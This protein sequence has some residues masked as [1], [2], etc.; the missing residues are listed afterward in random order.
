MRRFRAGIELASPIASS[1]NAIRGRHGF[2]AH[3]GLPVALS[4]SVTAR[5]DPEGDRRGGASPRLAADYS[6][7]GWMARKRRDD[8]DEVNDDI[9]A[10]VGRPRSPEEFG[11][12]KPEPHQRE[13]YVARLQ[14]ILDALEIPD[15]G[16]EELAYLQRLLCRTD[17]LRKFDP[18][19]FPRRGEDQ[20]IMLLRSIAETANGPKA[21]TLPLIKGVSS[22]LHDAWTNRG[23]EW[24]EAMDQVPLL[25]IH[26]TL[27]GLG[28]A[29]HLDE[30]VR[31]RLTQILGSPFAPPTKKPARKMVKPPTVS[32]PVWDEVIAMQ[33]ADRRRR[34]KSEWRLSKRPNKTTARRRSL[35]ATI[36][37]T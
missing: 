29:E 12:P 35:P 19:R 15:L 20:V 11:P 27:Q 32:Q 1:H 30:A 31:W 5:V 37:P 21:L 4:Q 23:L 17:R 33:K 7:G 10:R 16:R 26:A 34:A 25:E 28:L 22:C 6:V 8:D 2:G 24:L 9:P 13:E 36:G 3:V 14:S 18:K